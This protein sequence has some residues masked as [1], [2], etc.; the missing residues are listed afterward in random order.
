[1][2]LRD[3][4]EAEA[5][6]WVAWA[7]KP[8]HDSY[9]RFHRDEF[10]RLLPEPSGL[11][12][13]LG[14]GEG[15]FPRDL[16]ARGYQV[17]GV[18]GSATL[19]EAARE[20]D[21][22]GAYRLGDA[23]SLPLADASVDLVTALLSLHDMDDMEG[24]VVEA[25]RVLVPGGRLCAAVVHPIA[26]AGRFQ[27]QDAD[28]PFTIRGSYFEQRRYADDVERDGLQMTFTSIHR[29]LEA[30]VAALNVAGF[31]I[32]TI[33]EIADTSDPP[34]ARWRRIPLFLHLRALKP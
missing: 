21:P 22:D 20:A 31:Q 11:T 7:R 14:C 15:R 29:P 18:D 5:R 16:K 25:A 23:A 6:R 17:I 1:M 30:Y 8:G 26:T 27:A 24:A 33:R 19:I 28:A 2:T 9:W 10:L 4:W 32:E 34:V 13:D 3:A 12:L